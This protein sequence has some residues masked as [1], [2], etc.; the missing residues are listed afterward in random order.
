[1]AKTPPIEKDA[2]ISRQYLRAGLAMSEISAARKERISGYDE[3]LRKLE[4]FTDA[5]L[6]KS[7]DA[8]EELFKPSEL[9][10]TDL[11]KLL[12]APLHGLD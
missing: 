2:W 8:Q 9:L 11:E 12:D 3:R 5:L 6:I 4:D 7:V 10:S 1:M